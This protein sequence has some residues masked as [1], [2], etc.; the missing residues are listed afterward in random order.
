MDQ[1]GPAPARGLGQI[2]GRAMILATA[3][4]LDAI[5]GE[6]KVIWDRFR[7]PA[8][9]I[10]N[11]IGGLTRHLNHGANRRAKG[12]VLVAILVLG[13]LVSGNIIALLG[14]PV[15]VIT[16]AILLAQKSLIEH[17][18]HVADE[19]RLSTKGG[20]RAVGMIVGRD[21]KSMTPDQI[22]RS[23]IESAAENFSDGVT[24]PI[25]WCL[26]GGVPGILFYKAI[27]TADSMIGYMTPQYRD[28]GWAAAK[29]DDVVNWVPARLT[30]M[31]MLLAFGQ[32][33]DWPAVIV[34][35]GAHRSP[36]AGWP[37]S[38]MARILGAALSGPRSY[39]G[40][41]QDFP[42]VNPTGRR[43]LGP[44]DIDASTQVLWRVWWG[45]LTL[46]LLVGLIGWLPI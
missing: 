45:V 14:W 39:A 11:V 18:H 42:W 10:G 38:A 12:C 32:W 3:M 1:T 37:E 7:H 43:T 27:N 23:A 24:A 26:I 16:I 29:L 21:T 20:R 31:A 28:F 6:P 5:F 36:N 2:E 17:V 46:V 8:V 19:L 41:L 40:K 44:K 4:I 9:L 22:S 15:Q 30:A 33:R 13:S 34:D 25:F 35:G